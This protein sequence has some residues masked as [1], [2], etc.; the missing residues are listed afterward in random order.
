MNKDEA[1]QKLRE[2]DK[3][4]MKPVSITMGL[5]TET[6]LKRLCDLLNINRSRFI[7]IAVSH[8]ASYIDSLDDEQLKK[9]LMKIIHFD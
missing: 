1:Y 5:V 2:I 9:E 3:K 6:T 7:R 8:F 4:T